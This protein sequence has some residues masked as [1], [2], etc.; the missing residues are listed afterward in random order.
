MQVRHVETTPLSHRLE[1][2]ASRLATHTGEKGGRQERGK[3]LFLCMLTTRLGNQVAMGGGLSAGSE[4][5]FTSHSDWCACSS[6]KHA[7]CDDR[8]A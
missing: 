1:R 3:T 7:V 5:F 6:P 2:V 8:L 4:C